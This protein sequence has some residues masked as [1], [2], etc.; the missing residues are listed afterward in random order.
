MLP[1]RTP[2][3]ASAVLTC[4]QH[5]QVSAGS[6]HSVTSLLMLTSQTCAHDAPA[7]CAP[8][9]AVPHRE[10]SAGG[11]AV[12]RWSGAGSRARPAPAWPGCPP[13]LRS[14]RR[15][16]SEQ[17]RLV[18]SALR[19]SFAPMLSF[20]VGVPESVLSC[21][22]RR[23]SSAIRSSIRRRSSRSAVSSARS[24]TTSASF[25][26]TTASSRASSSRCPPAPAGRSGASDTSPD[27][28]QP[29]PHAQAPRTSC[30]DLPASAGALV[31]L[32]VRWHAWSQASGAVLDHGEMPDEAEQARP[33]RHAGHALLLAGQ[34]R[35]CPA[36]W[37]AA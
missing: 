8:A 32:P 30:R 17:S 31:R 21:P 14:L 20:D 36:A 24:I 3:G 22:S 37:P 13:R 19:R 27:H 12:F 23:S 4:P 34:P 25:A 11:S 26:S 1:G 5:R 9:S 35:R 7:G 16:R 18:R 2:G 33:R 10:H 15:S 6:S 29:H 28:A